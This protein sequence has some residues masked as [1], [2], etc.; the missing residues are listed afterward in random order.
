M[1]GTGLGFICLLLTY[2]F[3]LAATCRNSKGLA[4]GNAMLELL[5]G[6]GYFVVK[7]SKYMMGEPNHI[8]AYD[9][10]WWCKSHNVLIICKYES[11]D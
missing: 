1:L 10:H 4:G 6:G 3:L 5:A 11:K 9:H 2:I 7:R 8:G